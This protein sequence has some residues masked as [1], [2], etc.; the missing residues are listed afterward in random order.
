MITVYTFFYKNTERVCM[1]VC[2]S[3][4]DRGGM[5]VRENK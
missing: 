5:C 3:V 1:C 2:V 4:R